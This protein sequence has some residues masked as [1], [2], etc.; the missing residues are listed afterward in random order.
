MFKGGLAFEVGDVSGVKFWEEVWCGERSLKQ[1]FLDVFGLA[2]DP[3]PVV[4][5][6]FST[7]GNVIVWTPTLTHD[8]F[9]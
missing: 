5:F 6:N 3:T 8:L 7:Q 4:A 2:A 9:Y 1:D